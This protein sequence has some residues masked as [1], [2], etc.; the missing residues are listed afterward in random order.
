MNRIHRIIAA[1]ATLAGALTAMAAA[2]A[3][4]A[5]LPHGY[6]G[7][8]ASTPLPRPPGWNKHPPLPP[9]HVAG[10]AH[11]AT[12]PVHTVVIGGMPGWQIA[13]IAAA[14]ALAGAAVAVL[15]DHARTARKMHT[16]TA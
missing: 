9:G 1:I 4:Y 5:S 10:S 15:I 16:T 14:A 7:P 2:P 13:L 11:Q 12:V 8:A 6:G 3:A